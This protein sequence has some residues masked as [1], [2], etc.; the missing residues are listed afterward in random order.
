MLPPGLIV[1]LLGV[2]LMVKS[3]TVTLSSTFAL[4]VNEPLVPVMVRVELL[5]G[6]PAGMLT[7]RVELPDV[8][9]D[10]GE[11]EAVAPD[12]RPL[13]DKPTVPV[14]PFSAPIFTA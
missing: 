13:T 11:K 5:A 10:V 14:N 9:I 7:V 2:A 8:L 3:G 12:G 6:L 4:C 1:S